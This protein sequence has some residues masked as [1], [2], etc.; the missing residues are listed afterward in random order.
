MLTRK[1]LDEYVHAR[2]PYFYHCTAAE[3]LP[4]IAREGLKPW[5]G[6]A[7]TAYRYSL[8]EPRP[9]R[10]YIGSSAYVKQFQSGISLR[11]DLRLLDPATL[12]ADEDQIA[13]GLKYK[14][15]E[16]DPFAGQLGV[17]PG[18]D[19]KEPAHAEWLC[20][21]CQGDGCGDCH[22]TGLDYSLLPRVEE[23][24]GDWAERHA[25]IVDSPELTHFSL[26]LGSL[27][28]EGDIPLEAIS[29]DLKQNNLYVDTI[30]DDARRLADEDDSTP[31]RALSPAFRLLRAFVGWGVTVPPVAFPYGKETMH[32]ELDA[33]GTIVSPGPGVVPQRDFLERWALEVR[34]EAILGQFPRG[35]TPPRPRLDSASERVRV[36]AALTDD[37]V[38]LSL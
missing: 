12:G 3:N 19:F 20:P 5:D 38:G 13:Y 23:S 9:N 27:A 25:D 35:L 2:G 33:Q 17:E 7:G 6:A 1:Q 36:A 28:V 18:R 26:M 21:D 16:L 15:E 22:G 37:K 32:L 14:H 29:C 11:I 30:T 34:A 4:A 8:Y 10:V 31:L 24:R